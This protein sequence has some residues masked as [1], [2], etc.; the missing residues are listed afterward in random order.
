ME[1]DMETT[2]KRCSECFHAERIDAK[3]CSE[4]ANPLNNSDANFFAENETSK[5]NFF[6]RYKYSIFGLVF[7][8]VLIAGSYAFYQKYTSDI[9][10]LTNQ[11]SI[12]DSKLDDLES[13]MHDTSANSRN[14]DVLDKLD[15]LENDILETQNDIHAVKKDVSDIQSTVDGIQLKVGY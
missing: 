9:R 5:P 4:C 10:Q 7:S 3:F 6:L 2:S 11:I 8:L 1:I 14:Q 12:L 13:K 15:D